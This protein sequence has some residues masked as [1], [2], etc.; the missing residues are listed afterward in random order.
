[1]NR[2]PQAPA[3]SAALNP[4]AGAS[5]QR[6]WLMGLSLVL[7]PVLALWPGPARASD[8][9]PAAQSAAAQKP[10]AAK[11]VAATPTGKPAAASASAPKTMEE[12]VVDAVESGAGAKKRLTLMINGKEKKFITVPAA[13]PAAHPKTAAAPKPV[14]KTEEPAGHSAA[15][16]APAVR[17][18]V[19]AVVNPQASR[20]YIRAK[21]AALAGHE[22]KP[23]GHA[24]GHGGEA[25]WAYEGE[26]GPQAWGKLKPEFNVCAIGKRQ[27]PIN[28]EET[29]TLQ[30]PAEPLQFHYMA[31]SGTVV[32][33]GHTIQVDVLG[34]NSITVRGS[35]Y[36]LLQFHFHHPSEEKV[37]Y[38]GFA[39]VAHLVHRNAEGQL[40]VVAVLLDP[41]T[42]NNL[43][44]KVWTYMPLDAGD[45]VRMPIGLVD[46]NELLP[47]DQRYYQFMGSLT[48][49]PCTEGVLWLVLKQPVAVSREQIRLFSQL[50]PNNARPVQALNGRPVRDAQ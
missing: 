4:S 8:P 46:L 3:L 29:G 5:R 1:M 15:A 12:Q 33:N 2:L 22:A 23:D 32:N 39:M 24:S 45:R 42:A 16:H 36:K 19:P 25:H 21:A 50:F 17:P 31:S 48:T 18:T 34:D 11:P 26:N 37:N 20:Q 44:N 14:P 30:G 43:I 9:A 49:P 10:P 27:S 13:E 28:I 38:R 35:N 6:A 7:V 40:A 47:R 41:G